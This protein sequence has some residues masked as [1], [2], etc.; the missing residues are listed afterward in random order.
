LDKYPPEDLYVKGLVLAK[1]DAMG[2]CKIES[3]RWYPSK[4]FWDLAGSLSVSVSLSL[5]LPLPPF[6]LSTPHPYLDLSLLD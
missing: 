1:G 4:R 5:S 2:L 6:S 3:C